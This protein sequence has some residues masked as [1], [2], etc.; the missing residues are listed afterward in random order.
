MNTKLVIIVFILLLN[1]VTVFADEFP[2]IRYVN[3]K[4]GLNKREIPSVSCRIIGTL[5]Y[6]SRVYVS[7]KSN[8]QV[9]IVGITDYW[10]KC[11][12]GGWFWG[13]GG[14]LSTTMPNDT[15]PILG[16]WNTD[17]EARDYWYFLP[18]HSI[19]TGRKETD[20]G[21]RGTW[22]LVGNMLII[23]TQPT[24]F[25]T[26]E[27]VTFKITVTIINRDKIILNFYD[28]SKESLDRNNSIY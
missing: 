19:Y 23:I 8:R 6:G 11:Y 10:Y 4:D 22:E 7:E 14:Y 24:E 15:D 9:T 18:D 26:K 25:N 3:N 17:R 16:Y 2:S 21:W 5:L 12:S 27:S 20:D 13:F 1:P 28:G